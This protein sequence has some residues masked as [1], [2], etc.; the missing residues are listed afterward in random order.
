MEAVDFHTCRSHTQCFRWLKKCPIINTSPQGV[1][2]G[3]NLGSHYVVQ[4][5]IQL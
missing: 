1:L 2:K 5:E 4:V 3:K